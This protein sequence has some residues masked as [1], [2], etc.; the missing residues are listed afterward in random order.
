MTFD[1]DHRTYELSLAILNEEIEYEAW[2]CEFL[3]AGPSGHIRRGSPGE[4]P[5]ISRFL[6]APNSHQN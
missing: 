1:K 2:F 4:S 3:G 5:Y 6:V